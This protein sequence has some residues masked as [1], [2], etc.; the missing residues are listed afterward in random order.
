MMLRQSS[1]NNKVGKGRA[2]VFWCASEEEVEPWLG[3]SGGWGVIPC[4]KRLW[5]PFLVRAHT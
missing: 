5:V 3:G 1:Q 4:T 2:Y